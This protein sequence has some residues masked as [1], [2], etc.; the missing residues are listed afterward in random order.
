MKVRVRAQTIRFRLGREEMEPLRSGERVE[1]EIAFGTA[2]SMAW[3]V[4]LGSIDA[5]PAYVATP[6]KLRLTIPRLAWIDDDAAEGYQTTIDPG[7]GSAVRFTIE[8][9]YKCLTPRDSAEDRDSYP[10][11][12]VPS[13]C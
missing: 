2:G 10:H 3:S 11:P 1:E 9:D 8:R 6:G 4:E 13:A 12:G 5:A 7:P